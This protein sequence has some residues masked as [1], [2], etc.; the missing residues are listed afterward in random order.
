MELFV[1]EIMLNKNSH[2]PIYFQIQKQL[3]EKIENIVLKPGDQLPTERELSAEL[4]V[5]RV[6]IRKA[7]RGLITE[8]LCEKKA[9]KGIF[10]A[11]K[12]LLMN[13]HNLVGT[14]QFIEN[15]GYKL[16]TTVIEQKVIVPTPRIAAKLEM[17]EGSE[18][19]FLKRVRYVREEPVIMDETILP[20]VL[21]PDL[22]DKDFNQ[23]LYSILGKYY[24]IKAFRAKGSYNIQVSREDESEILNLKLNTPLLIKNT[25]AYSNEQQPIEYNI[26]KYRTDK[27]EFIFDTMVK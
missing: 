19:L 14:T 12:K 17:D 9:G 21:Y 1:L 15:F 13:I 23:S 22:I 16:I 11:D 10:V 24:Q 4:D 18:A 3:R 27:F 8:G 2:I 25:V 7:M 5:S 26:T 20:L 6:T